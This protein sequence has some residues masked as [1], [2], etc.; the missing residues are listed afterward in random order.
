MEQAKAVGNTGVTEEMK[1][2]LVET[3]RQVTEGK[4]S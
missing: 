4:V 3:I 2:K 1:L